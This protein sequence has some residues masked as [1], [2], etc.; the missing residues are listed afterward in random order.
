VPWT[1]LQELDGLKESG[2]KK[3]NGTGGKS[4]AGHAR[5]AINALREGFDSGDGFFLGQTL[6]EYR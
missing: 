4:V 2:K 6:R 1:V 5:A 3:K